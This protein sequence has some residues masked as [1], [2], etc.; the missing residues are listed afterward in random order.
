MSDQDL[1]YL[2]SAGRQL[3]AKPYSKRMSHRQGLEG[4]VA[5]AEVR[6]CRCWVCGCSTAFVSRVSAHF[7]QQQTFTLPQPEWRS[8]PSVPALLLLLLL[9]C[10]CSCLLMTLLSSLTC[11]D[12]RVSSRAHSRTHSRAYSSAQ[13]GTQY[14]RQQQQPKQP[15][16]EQK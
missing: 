7:E 5:A 2:A 14:D 10:S 13:R 11:L 4:C 3:V 9:S 8:D 15:Q 16:T 6:V 12:T 1:I